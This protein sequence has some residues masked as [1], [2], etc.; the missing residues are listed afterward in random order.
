[1]TLGGCRDCAIG[2]F[3]RQLSQG[4]ADSGGVASAT[5]PAWLLRWQNLAWSHR[6]VFN[7]ARTDLLSSL[8]AALRPTSALYRLQL[9][10]V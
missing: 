3:A 2:H 5:L 9:S 6:R 4:G 10:S 8:A 1:V 7:E